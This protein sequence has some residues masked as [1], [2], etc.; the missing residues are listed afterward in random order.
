MVFDGSLA[1][2]IAKRATVWRYR[3]VMELLL[4]EDEI[5]WDNRTE[6]EEEEK[7]EDDDDISIR[8]ISSFQN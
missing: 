3:N 1:V 2:F 5:D 7:E 6:E 4:T 8:V